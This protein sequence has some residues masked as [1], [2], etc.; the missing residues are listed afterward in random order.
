MSMI[1]RGLAR[2]LCVG[3]AV[4]SVAGAGTPVRAEPTDT[5]DPA[6][7]D[8]GNHVTLITGDTVVVADVGAGRR[9]VT[10]KPGEGRTDMTFYQQTEGDDVR[11][12]PS[13]ASGLLAAGALDPELF[14][15][16]RL[17]RDG[18]A[19]ESGEGLPLIIKYTGGRV[20]AALTTVDGATGRRVLESID[21]VAVEQR[22]DDAGALWA[23]IAGGPATASLAAGVGKV[24]LDT[25]VE[26]LNDVGNAQIGVPA[27]RQAGLTGEGV[28]VAV[29]DTGWDH[30]HPDLQDRVIGEW[31]FF[32]NSADA[33]DDNGHGTH[34]AG[35]VAGSG[36]ASGGRYAGVAPDADLLVGKVLDAG[37]SGFTS[38]VLAGMEWA[39]AQG[40]DIVNMSLGSR[41]PSSGGDVLSEAAN[42]L[43]AQSDTLFVVAAGNSGPGATTIG[44][45]A[46]ADS[47][48][49]LG[50]VDSTGAIASFSSRG[51]RLGNGAVKPD[52]T[53]P[54]VNVTSA[55]AKGTPIGDIDPDGPIGP[56]DDNYTVLSGTSM[57]T[58]SAAGA[59]A[60]IAQQHPDWDGERLKAAMTATASPQPGQTVYEQGAGLVDLAR[61]TSQTVSATPNSVGAE[62]FTWPYADNAPV[63]R[64]VSYVNDGDAPVTLRISPSSSGATSP[65]GLLTLSATEVTVPAHGKAGVTVTITPSAALAT[66]AGG[67]YSWR[68]EATSPDGAVRVQTTVGAMF[69]PESYDFTFTALDRNG[70]LPRAPYPGFVTVFP[71]DRFGGAVTVWVWEGS[72]KTTLRMIKG[73]YGITAMTSTTGTNR[74]RTELTLQSRPAT[75]LDENLAV[76][77]DA[78]AAKPVSV[79]VPDP[80][81]AP[82]FNEFG[83]LHTSVNA[84]GERETSQFGLWKFGTTPL[85]FSAVP[86]P[87]KQ[88]DDRYRY[89]YRSTLVPPD[90]DP[91][92]PV[93]GPVYALV[94]HEQGGVPDR[95]SYDVPIRR[96]AKVIANYGKT[97]A[98][99]DQRFGHVGWFTT[100]FAPG[101]FTASAPSVRNVNLASRRTEYYTADSQ[102]V[103]SSMLSRTRTPDGSAYYSGGRQLSN[104]RSYRPGPAGEEIWN[105]PAAGP[106]LPAN[107]QFLTRTGDR[108]IPQLALWGDSNPDHYNYNAAG[109]TTGLASLYRG[110]TLLGS[111]T[112]PWE[113]EQDFAGLRFWDVNAETARYRLDVTANRSTSWYG[114]SSQRVDA[115][116]T[117]SSAHTDTTT[118][119]PVSVLRFQ[120]PT[121]ENGI[122]P[123]GTTVAVPFVVQQ[124]G[125]ARCRG[126]RGQVTVEASYDDGA[127]WT[128]M[129]VK[130]RGT[131]GEVELTHPATGWVSLRAAGSDTAGN[132]F[133]QTVIRA[134]EIG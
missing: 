129:P 28:T 76:A 68:L 105:Y 20:P 10:V 110:D 52:I 1:R 65:E 30:D 100:G 74:V 53:A 3:L 36:A 123:G 82:L 44:A 85:L 116:W 15:V 64:N 38:D 66:P 78:R 91:T 26:A 41:N 88:R 50:A 67:A 11:V 96:L 17:I 125:P 114:P 6:A 19:D 99:G 122:A 9:A 113:D 112:R 27:A 7:V 87:R 32:R 21:A 127:T 86:T 56:I 115:S 77:F 16:S 43:S 31:N 51:P 60:L 54:G 45:L 134:Y 104:P 90:S 18:L 57:A 79:G 81:V 55:R 111:W 5:S 121:D 94:E 24:L 48:L 98:G 92:V 12:V 47:T 75:T 131:G 37:G 133:R 2:T 58:P 103:F 13:D 128:R 109:T 70:E 25:R 124:Q 40:A 23:D 63:T 22:R 93:T 117:F 39:V 61:A 126:L 119:L 4:A 80:A 59:V 130:L 106:A 29:L 102:V 95:L 34:V 120:P 108:I 8:S 46:A 132:T 101:Q 62:L 97:R 72:P 89:Y 49:T 118:P 73:T 35:T 69:E 83:S 107:G 84:S 42:N 33:N 14:N 71:L